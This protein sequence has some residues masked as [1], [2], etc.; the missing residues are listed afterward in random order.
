MSA[1]A[2]WRLESL[3]FGTVYRYTPG[4]ADWLAN[5]LPAEGTGAGRTTVADVARRDVPTCRLTETIAEVRE[6]VAASGC[7]QCVVVNERN[8]VLGRVRAEKLAD[9]PQVPVERVMEP[10]P[11]TYRLD[12]LAEEAAARLKERKVE[13]VLITTTDGELVGVFY[14]DYQENPAHRGGTGKR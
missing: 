2:A 1:R 13:S 8:V 14:G 9:D 3:G 10:G 5:G 11:A 4:K 12:R 7:D 6:R